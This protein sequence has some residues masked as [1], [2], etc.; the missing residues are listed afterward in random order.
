VETI[1][2]RFLAL[3]PRSAELAAEAR[4][5]FPG[6]VTH[7]IRYFEPFGLYVDRAQGSRKWDVDGNEI[8]DYVMGH[9]ALLLGHAHPTLTDAI[10]RQV[11]RGTHYGASHELEIAWARAV[12]GLIPSAEQVRFVSSGTEATMLA[13][14]LARAFTGRSHL[15]KLR[16]HFHG[17]NDTI[18]A[19]GP[20]AT[21]TYGSAGLPP[22]WADSIHVV[23]QHDTDAIGTALDSK[24]FAAVILEPTGYSWSTSPLDDTVPAFLRERTQETET[25]LIFDEV[26]TGFRASMSGAQGRLG[27]TPD[28]TTLAKILAG[29]L[30]GGAVAGRADLLNQMTIDKEHPNPSRVGHPGTFNANPLSSVAGT[31]MLTEVATGEPNELAN[32]RAAQ[33]T[34]GMN[35]LIR[36]AEVPGAAYADASMVHILLGREVDAPIDD[37]TWNWGAAGAQAKV[38]HTPAK[39]VWPFSRAMLNRGVDLIHMGAM[40]SAVHSEADIDATLDAFEGSL[41]DLRAEAI[42]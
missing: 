25:I 16:H 7:D 42:L 29:G 13:V 10:K 41:A 14:R 31:A 2:D 8:I 22:E 38:P 28:L 3:H 30:P 21:D 32:A 34:S 15:L 1:D 17:W 19:G 11:D 37:L 27:I 40:V 9:G 12:Q 18:A 6:G 23:D 33:L 35:R 20:S 36:R 24:A 5:I 26:I 39:L 4:R